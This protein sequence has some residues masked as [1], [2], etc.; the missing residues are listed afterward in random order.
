MRLI[1]IDVAGLQALQGRFHSLHDVASRQALLSGPHFHPD[2]GRDDHPFASAAGLQPLAD[3]GFGLAA[4]I[5]GYPARVNVRGVD[6]VESCR[7]ERV[8]QFE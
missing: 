3:D 8:E 4:L 6:A 5:A 7:H 1:E 2:L